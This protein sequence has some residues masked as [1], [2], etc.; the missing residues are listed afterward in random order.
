MRRGPTSAVVMLT[1]EERV[2][3]TELARRRKTPHD[4]STGAQ[5]I[6]LSA[7][8]PTASLAEIGRPV[9]LCRVIVPTQSKRFI[10]HRMTGLSD[11]PKRGAPRS[12]QDH[13]IERLI[14]ITLKS[15][16]KGASHWSTRT[17]AATSGVSQS[18]VS[19][20]W[21]ALDCVLTSVNPSSVP[22]IP[23]LSKRC[24]TSWDCT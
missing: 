6:L 8:Q 23:C 22:K 17:V 21:R 7:N 4:L 12:I 19:R 18:V 13:D 2:L 16:P 14:Q 3:L 10:T 9:V 1:G 15:L 24:G 11:A 5:V 20:I